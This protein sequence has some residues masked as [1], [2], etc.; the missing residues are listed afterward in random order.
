MS[1]CSWECPRGARSVN[2]LLHSTVAQLPLGNFR[3]QIAF[4]FLHLAFHFW[5]FVIHREVALLG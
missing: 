2:L 4:F 3:G 1:K 5:K